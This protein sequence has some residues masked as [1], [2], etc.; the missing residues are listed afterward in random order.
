MMT[1]FALNPLS[2]LREG[3]CF[4]LNVQWMLSD[5]LWSTWAKM[6]IHMWQLVKHMYQ[7]HKK[8]FLDE[9]D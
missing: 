1:K 3:D 8:A 2:G 7:S 9:K 6:P 5:D 4:F